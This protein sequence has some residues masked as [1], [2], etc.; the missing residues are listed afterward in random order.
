MGVFLIS[1]NEDMLV[2][3]RVIIL[4]VFVGAGMGHIAWVKQK[5][6]NPLVNVAVALTS[7]TCVTT[8]VK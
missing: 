3:E 7:L 5:F 2:V 4:L 6:G 1:R 8:L